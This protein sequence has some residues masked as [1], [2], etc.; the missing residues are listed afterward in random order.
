LQDS[1]GAKQMKMLK[2]SFTM[3]LFAGII[4]VGLGLIA[5]AYS[6]SASPAQPISE[7]PLEAISLRGPIDGT[8]LVPYSEFSLSAGH[9]PAYP[10][11]DFVFFFRCLEY[12]HG[13]PP[14]PITKSVSGTATLRVPRGLSKDG[15]VFVGWRNGNHIFQPWQTFRLPED[16]THFYFYAIW[17]PAVYITLDAND[18][19]SATQQLRRAAGT[20]MRFLPHPSTK[21]GYVFLGW[22]TTP[23]AT[24]GSRLTASATVPNTN[25]TYWARW[26]MPINITVNYE[27]LVNRETDSAR[28][29][30]D[31]SIGEITHLFLTGFGINLVPQP[32]GARYEP[33]LNNVGFS[34]PDILDVNPSN[35]RTVVF[36]FVDFP[37][38]DGLIA[39]LARPI[40]G[41]EG[42]TQMHLGD[43]V[44][45]TVLTPAMLRRAIVHEISHIFGAIDCYN[46][47]CVMDISR[48]HTIHDNW[49]TH[50]RSDINNYLYVRMRNNPHLRGDS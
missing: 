25:T 18:G 21:E 35:Y 9:E 3:I 22:F 17:A 32:S 39:G 42:T 23:E 24:G 16:V 12:T 46:F 34:A 48:H 14:A 26:S 27:S 38:N 15:Y 31:T 1:K 40:R 36:R 29:K 47:G 41:I 44:V 30:A 13:T 45:T 19:V 8:I 50:C 4:I 43:I 6:V 2:T 11:Y 10:Q 33:M 20:Q 49:C 5:Q 28:E 37:L 7:P